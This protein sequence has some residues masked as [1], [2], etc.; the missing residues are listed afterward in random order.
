MELIVKVFC[1]EICTNFEFNSIELL[2]FFLSCEL[3]LKQ[4]HLVLHYLIYVSFSDFRLLE[5]VFVIK[6]PAYKSASV[7]LTRIVRRFPNVC[8]HLVPFSLLVDF[9][10]QREFKLLLCAIEVIV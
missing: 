10:L 6:R 9:V 7:H 3:L 1:L 4:L 5:T 8:N 2:C